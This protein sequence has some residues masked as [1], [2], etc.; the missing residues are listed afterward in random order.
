MAEATLEKT[1][2][3]TE[4]ASTAAAEN[5]AENVAENIAEA[6]GAES[7]GPAHAG[8]TK[9]VVSEA[10]IRGSL[11]AVA[12]YLVGLLGLLELAF[13]FRFALVAIRVMLH[14]EATIRLLDLVGRS[15]FRDSQHLVIVA[16]CHACSRAGARQGR[17]F[18]CPVPGLC[19]QAD[20]D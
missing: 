5:I 15:R 2:K 19:L 7:A 1:A 3:P 10:V 6:L 11:V 18:Q 9:A 16:F 14:G 4:A 17:P 20:L 12:Q 8:A 13:R